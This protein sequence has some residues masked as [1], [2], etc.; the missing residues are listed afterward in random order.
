MQK[1]YFDN[2]ATTAILPEVIEHI[3]ESMYEL[4]G[5]PSSTHSLGRK[6][7][8]AIELAR[9]SVAH[10][11]GAKASEI[12]FT[13]G[14]TEANNMIIHHAVKILGVK[15]I[16]TS[17]AEHKAVLECLSNTHN[18]SIIYLPLDNSGAINYKELE[19]LLS[20]QS[21]KTMVSLMLINN[22]TGTI[23]DAKLVGDLCKTYQTIFH[24]DSVQ[25]IGHEV[26]NFEDIGI[27]YATCSA[28]KFHGP[29]GVGFV[30]A[31][32]QY[33]MS[34]MIF[35]GGQEKGFRPGTENVT[36]VQGLTKALAI[37][38]DHLDQDKK[39]IL[40]IREAFIHELKKAFDNHVIFNS[41]LKDGAYNILN[42]GF[43]KEIAS[44][45]LLFSLDIKGVAAA[46][47]SAC[48]SGSLQGSHVL[49]AIDPEIEKNYVCIRF[50]FSKL[51]TLNEVNYCIEQL[52][53]ILLSR[54]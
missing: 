12:I 20:D 25:H 54:G 41:P 51:N 2:A 28:H 52:K 46:S 33:G 43:S 23:L 24:T 18:V 29:K 10:H 5:N 44:D 26:I 31:N 4:Y 53:E 6:T 7:K 30:Y 36:G 50:S 21:L 40:S 37:A 11:F 47:G 3:S 15:R 8:N 45:L 13:S 9:R 48:S 1:V 35:G 17:E 16:I 34:A 38:Y 42:V 14:A 32:I 22:E 49:R 39:H 19:G 27:H